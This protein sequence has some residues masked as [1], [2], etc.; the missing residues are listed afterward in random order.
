MELL[1]FLSLFLSLFLSQ[2]TYYVIKMHLIDRNKLVFNICSNKSNSFTRGTLDLFFE[3]SRA[4]Y[5]NSV[6]PGHELESSP[7][8]LY[9]KQLFDKFSAI[10][11]EIQDA[12]RSIN[13]SFGIFNENTLR[14]C[15]TNIAHDIEGYKSLIARPYESVNRYV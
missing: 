7:N 12:S 4:A 5:F 1:C 2:L 3:I 15:K 8:P 13:K 10:H 6:C 14:H 9:W 11:E